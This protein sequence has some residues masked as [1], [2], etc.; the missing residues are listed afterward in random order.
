MKKLLFF[1]FALIGAMSLT[2]ENAVT[3]CGTTLDPAHGSVYVADELDFLI[4][5][6]IYWTGSELTFSNVVIEGGTSSKDAKLIYIE[7][8][9]TDKVTIKLFGDNV[10]SAGSAAN[11]NMPAIVSQSSISFVCENSNLHEMGYVASLTI[12]SGDGVYMMG[13]NTTMTLDRVNVAINSKKGSALYGDESSNP[14]LYIKKDSRLELNSAASE[15]VIANEEYNK[16]ASIT[17]ESQ[18]AIAEPAGAQI[19]GGQ[20]VVNEEPVKGRLLFDRIEWETSGLLIT[21]KIRINSINAANLEAWFPEIIK[22]GHVSYDKE[23]STLRM[24]NATIEPDFSDYGMS[25]SGNAN[26][27]VELVGKNVLHAQKQGFSNVKNSTLNITGNGSLDIIADSHY[28][29]DLAENCIL[30][31]DNTTVSIK[32]DGY[33][34]YGRNDQS[35]AVN[36]NKSNLTLEATTKAVV[37]GLKELNLTDCEI[38]EPEGAIIVKGLIVDNKGNDIA[39]KVVIGTPKADALELISADDQNLLLNPEV[40]IFN[41]AGQDVTSLKNNLPQG[42]YILRAGKQVQKISVR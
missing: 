6:T 11:A 31:I 7:G 8:N 16:F 27:T 19:S 12:N 15:A 20:V 38:L 42:T 32:G 30:N 29:I 4:E 39:D 21:K 36:I 14:K 28:G 5:G 33:D 3:I 2:A 10:I 9:S 13:K 25:V 34:I 1:T 35:I 41:V 37:S 17:C 40:R 24:E 23:T 22:A 26:V 18:I